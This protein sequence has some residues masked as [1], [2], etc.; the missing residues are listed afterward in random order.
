M[1]GLKKKKRDLAQSYKKAPTPT[2]K[3]YKQRDNTK[4]NRDTKLRL[5]NDY[6]P[7]QDDQLE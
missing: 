5:Q 4:K 2:E 7:T 1:Y 6:G 3:S